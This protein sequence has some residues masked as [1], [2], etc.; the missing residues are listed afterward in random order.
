MNETGIPLTWVAALFKR[1][2]ALYLHKWTSAIE[3]IE[4]LAVT[5]WSQALSGITGEQIK[6]GLANL[7]SD[8]PP[9]AIAFKALCEGKQTNGLGLDHTPPYH[10]EVKRDRLI[11]SDEAKEK[12]RK[13][14]SIGMGEIKSIL[15]K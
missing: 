7:D 15:K 1:F 12:H 4:D 3:G 11:E 8:W 14:F 2:Q 6:T 9:T 13:A 10:A 5:E